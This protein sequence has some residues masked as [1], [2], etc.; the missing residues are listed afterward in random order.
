M[1]LK[2]PPPPPPHIQ[3]RWSRW[4]PMALDPQEPRC[5]LQVKQQNTDDPHQEWPT[6]PEG[7]SRSQCVRSK[8]NWPGHVFSAIR[9][10]AL[11]EV[12]VCVRCDDDDDDDVVLQVHQAH[13]QAQGHPARHKIASCTHTYTNTLTNTHSHIHTLTHTHI[14]TYKQTDCRPVD[15]FSLTSF[16]TRWSLNRK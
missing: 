16:P 15:R 10:T 9:I 7:E 1:P 11:T 8:N 6:D 13:Q 3:P 4:S 14:Y 2:P 12:C 5:T